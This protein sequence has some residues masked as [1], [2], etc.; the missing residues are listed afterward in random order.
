MWGR[1]EGPMSPARPCELRKA[2]PLFHGHFHPMAS[3]LPDLGALKAKS[4]LGRGSH[5]PAPPL[6]PSP[7]RA[8]VPGPICLRICSAACQLGTLPLAPS[9]MLPFSLVLFQS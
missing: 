5:G 7:D 2:L 9:F 3:P 6:P 8:G 4:L 1:Q